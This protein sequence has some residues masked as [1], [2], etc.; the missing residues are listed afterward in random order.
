MLVSHMACD[1]VPKPIAD[2]HSPPR[3]SHL[4]PFSASSHSLLAIEIPGNCPWKPWWTPGYLE[5]GADA[6][7]CR[8]L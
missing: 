8:T 7:Q 1:P 4:I 3:R 2:A 5:G 6:A